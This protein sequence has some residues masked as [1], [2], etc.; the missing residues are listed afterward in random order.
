MERGQLG[1]EVSLDVSKAI[2]MTVFRGSSR[3]DLPCVFC[4]VITKT[5]GGAL[6]LHC[7]RFLRVWTHICLFSST[8]PLAPAS[9]QIIWEVELTYAG[10]VFHV[11]QLS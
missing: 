8:Q 10:L 5:V 1:S 11:Q 6:D 3:S 4:A 9:C 2:F 7:V